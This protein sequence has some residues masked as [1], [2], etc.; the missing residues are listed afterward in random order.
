MYIIITVTRLSFHLRQANLSPSLSNKWQES[1]GD[2]LL[3]L[4]SPFNNTIKTMKV[5]YCGNLLTHFS[6]FSLIITFCLSLL[7]G[8]LL[9]RLKAILGRHPVS[10]LPFFAFRLVLITVQ[11]CPQRFF[12]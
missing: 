10:R 4:I 5:D 3:S 9:K 1:N 6:H 7:F 8:F 2:N 11:E 12:K